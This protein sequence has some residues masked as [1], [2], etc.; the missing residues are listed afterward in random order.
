MFRFQAGLIGGLT[1]EFLG[2]QDITF[3]GTEGAKAVFS[4]HGLGG[5]SY[6]YGVTF[7]WQVAQRLLIY[8]ELDA[9]HGRYYTKDYG[10]NFGFKYAF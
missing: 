3:T 9:E 2:D 4:G 10:F 6:Y 8:G 5:T 7:D 1:H